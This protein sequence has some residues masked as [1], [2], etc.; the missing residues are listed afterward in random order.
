M[1]AESLAFTPHLTENAKYSE[2][3]KPLSVHKIQ[4]QKG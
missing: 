2:G 4:N 1:K 3:S